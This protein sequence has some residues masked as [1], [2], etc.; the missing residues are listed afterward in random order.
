MSNANVTCPNC[1]ASLNVPSEVLGRKIKCPKCQEVV[2]IPAPAEISAAGGRGQSGAPAAGNRAAA[3][4]PQT[5]K[6]G[7]AMAKPVVP[8]AVAPASVPGASKAQ[9]K[10]ASAPSGSAA[11]ENPP[12]FSELDSQVAE[13]PRVKNKRKQANPWPIILLG[14]GAVTFLIVIVA[15]LIIFLPKVGSNSGGP[16]SPEIQY[17]NET[18]TEVGKSVSIPIVVTYPKSYTASDKERWTLQVAPENPTGST[19]NP[20]TGSLTWAPTTRDAGKS[21]VLGIIIQDSANKDANNRGTFQVRVPA[22]SP[23]IMAALSHLNNKKVTYTVSLPKKHTG[24]KHEETVPILVEF[25]IGKERV[26]L[27]DYSSA[28]IAKAKLAVIDDTKFE[29]LGLTPALTA[30]LS[31]V[32]R[33]GA[34]LVAPTASLEASEFIKKWFDVPK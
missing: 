10:P 14:V 29:E 8:M 9:P 19:W 1:S 24:M 17:V 7:P 12:S 18:T 5:P 3:A 4:R 34:I 20:A 11:Q 21:H 13:K 27:Y 26:D 16:S 25:Q 32:R 31:Y 2:R 23:G 22:L 15:F 30:P 28:E 33:D 6:P